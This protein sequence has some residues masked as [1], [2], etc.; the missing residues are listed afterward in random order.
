M[1][2]VFVL[3]LLAIFGMLY[4]GCL[5]I[6]K[7]HLLQNASRIDERKLIQSS[8]KQEDLSL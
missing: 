5:L 3:L 2:N 8:F 1:K 4:A 6:G 7:S